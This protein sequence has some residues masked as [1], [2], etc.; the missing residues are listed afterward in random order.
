MDEGDGIMRRIL[1]AAL[2]LALA[3]LP[4]LRS[5]T[6]SAN[7]IVGGGYSSSYAGE[8]VFTNNAAGETGQMSAIFF[9]DGTQPWPSGVVGLLVCAADKTT[10]NVPSNQSYR[11]RW[12]S[13]TVY[14]TV[15]STVAPGQNGFFIYDFTVP[16]GTPPGTVTTFYGDV[17][18]IA[19]GSELRPEGYFQINTTPVPSLTLTLTPNPASVAVGSTQQFT[20]TGGPTGTDPTW[21]VN[22]GCGAITAAGLFAAT[23]TNSVSQPCTVVA[24]VAGTTASAPVTVYGPAATLSCVANP[25]TTVANGGAPGGTGG[26]AISLKDINGNTVSNASTPAIRIANNTPAVVTVTPADGFVTPSNGV[27]LLTY[28]T[29]TVPGTIQVS[30]SATGVLGCNVL[31]TSSAPGS[32]VATA[33]SFDPTV[34]ASDGGSTSTLR[35]DVVDASGNRDVNDSTTVISVS[36]D[37][38]AN[39]CAL[40]GGGGSATGPAVSGRA[41]FSV[42]STTTPGSCLWSATT[43]STAI[44]GSSATLTTQIVG[45]ANRLGVTS[46]DSPHPAAAPG[47]SC[48]ATGTNTDLSCTRVVVEVRD[49]NGVRLT[50]STAT[51]TATL[52]TST[53]T[54][55]GGGNAASVN[56]TATATAGR[57]TFMFTSRGAYSAC[58]ITFSASGLAG[59]NTTVAWT[60]QAA[61]HLACLFTPQSIFNDNTATATADAAARDAFG[62]VVTGTNYSVTFTKQSGSSTVLVTASPQSMLAGHAYF[63]VRST[64]NSGSDLYLPQI[65]PGSGTLPN[66]PVSCFVTVHP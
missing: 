66:A 12:F 39:I 13:D 42:V 8:S 22:G 4:L 52:E 21:S 30:A 51:L 41:T 60:P 2:A 58:N 31:I 19:T 43:N 57:A 16:A 61:D 5:S 24:T 48:G 38:G 40:A 14:A 53:C 59:T 7:P 6:A 26:I 54:G 37:S 18:I 55:A 63:T 11:S 32:G 27:V 3:G 35:V 33:S 17:G 1:I 47:G 23:A 25:A 15:T 10:C 9:N 50:G 34:I 62:N 20:L 44:T 64:T 49:F 45:A 36:R 65:A 46:N 29:T 56:P 28:A